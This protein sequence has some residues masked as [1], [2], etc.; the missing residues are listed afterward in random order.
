LYW[1]IK[2]F[3]HISKLSPFI[4]SKLKFNLEKPISESDQTLQ[5]SNNINSD[6]IYLIVGLV[7]TWLLCCVFITIVAMLF[8]KKQSQGTQE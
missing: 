7:V 1:Q 3:T 4:K 2:N 6:Q 8:V 5:T